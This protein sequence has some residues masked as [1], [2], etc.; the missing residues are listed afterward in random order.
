MMNLVEI[1]D[2]ERVLDGLDSMMQ[3]TCDEGGIVRQYVE[4]QVALL[5]KAVAMLAEDRSEWFPRGQWATIQSIQSRTDA[6]LAFSC[7]KKGKE[8][9]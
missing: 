5:I 1:S 9:P 2:S 3:E 7:R 6:E 4:I 8:R